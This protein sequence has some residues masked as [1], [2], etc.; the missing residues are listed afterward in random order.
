MDHREWRTKTT[1]NFSE[2]LAHYQQL[3]EDTVA[4]EDVKDAYSRFAMSLPVEF[5]RFSRMLA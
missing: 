4:W 2:S 5:L 1:S 3:P